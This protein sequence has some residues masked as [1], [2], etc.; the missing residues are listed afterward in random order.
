MASAL[1][2]KKRIV[3]DYSFIKKVS[4]F[5]TTALEELAYE[6][7]HG[8]FPL[9]VEAVKK[10]I[11]QQ[12]D[13]QS[14]TAAATLLTAFTYVS[15]RTFIDTLYQACLAFQKATNSPS[16]K[17]TIYLISSDPDNGIGGIK[18]NI[19]YS[20]IAKPW[21]GSHVI[22]VTTE[23]YL[24]HYLGNPV[25]LVDDASY[26]GT[27]LVDTAKLFARARQV[28]IVVPYISNRAGKRLVS[29]KNV[30][31]Y[32]MHVM[33]SMAELLPATEHAYFNKALNITNDP[34]A[35]FSTLDN[36]PTYFYHRVA[37]YKSS[38][39]LPIGRGFPNLFSQ[40]GTVYPLVK[41]CPEEMVGR[42]RQ[43]K[44]TTS[45]SC[46]PPYYKH[47]EPQEPL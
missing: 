31:L 8:G 28:H 36:I 25:V 7:E 32:F 19:F 34:Q 3:Q 22:P 20:G 41:N 24:T 13:P 9:D 30:A 14:Q 29:L 23:Q 37:D 26:S 16:N 42:K 17:Q 4:H 47:S 44:I 5:Q 45:T 27:Q 15:E 6:N 43:F 38:F 12:K 1:P 33:K 21:L 10:Y 2:L 35:T 39:P 40:D 11:Q 46:P 18:S